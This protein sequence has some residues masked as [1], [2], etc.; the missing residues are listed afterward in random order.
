MT[1][2]SILSSSNVLVLIKL[3]F[4]Y[5]SLFVLWLFSYQYKNAF[6]VFTSPDITVLLTIILIPWTIILY[7]R[8]KT[9][10]PLSDSAFLAF[11]GLSLWF[12]M[13]SL[14]SQSEFYKTQ[15]TLCYAFYTIPGFFMGYAIISQS[16]ERLKRLMLALFVFALP[17]LGKVYHGFFINGLSHTFEVLNTNYLVTGQTLG[18]GLLVLLSYS[19]LKEESTAIL[20]GKLLLG[21]LFF[22]A[23]I[24]IGGRGPVIA[25][26]SAL[27]IFYCR[28]F[29]FDSTVKI[30]IHL[31][32]FIFLCGLTV[33]L[34][35]GL[36]DHTG[37]HFHQRLAPIL[38]GQLDEAVSERLTYYQSAVITFLKH[39]IIGVGFGGWPVSNRLGDISLHPHNIFLEIL[40]ET[41]LIGFAFFAMLLYFCFRRLTLRF[42]FS[43]PERVSLTLLTVF[44]F[45]NALKTGDLHDNLL[46][47]IMLSLCAGIKTENKCLNPL[48]SNDVALLS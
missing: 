44:A 41:G 37:S 25:A 24:N 5:E 11:L 17:I 31:G 38:S 2:K 48:N 18:T 29:W 21:A 16:T 33:L 35:N 30:G 46:L 40:S 28:Q 12:I 43:T 13:S 22:Y 20:W 47:F 3:L 39:P 23:L 26:G 36:F 34:L 42:L 6:E 19:H 1:L 9:R 15:K 14:W 10:P 8:D 45:M 32:A 27:A 7:W 4:S